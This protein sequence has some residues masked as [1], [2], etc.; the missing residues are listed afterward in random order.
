[1]VFLNKK[2]IFIYSSLSRVAE[3]SPLGAALI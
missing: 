1:L 2:R 3:I